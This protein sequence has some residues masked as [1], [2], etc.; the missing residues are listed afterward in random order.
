MK[1]FKNIKIKQIK[2][3]NNKIGIL[4]GTLILLL[5]ITFSLLRLLPIGKFL[6]DFIF[7]FLFGWSKYLIYILLYS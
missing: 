2:N 6:D 5:L 3:S 1:D 4:L 7:S